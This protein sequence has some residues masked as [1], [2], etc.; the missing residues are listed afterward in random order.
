VAAVDKFFFFYQQVGGEDAWQA[1]LAGTRAEVIAKQQPRYVTVLDLSPIIDETFTR[2]QVDQVRYRGP[3]YF[4]FDGSDIADVMDK[5]RTFMGKL[6][7][8]DVDPLM[9]RLYATGGRGFHI[10]VPQEIFLPK[11]PKQGTQRLPQIYKEMAYELY[12]DTLDLRVYSA[13]K[14]RMWR[15]VN[16]KRENGRFKVPITPDELME[17]TADDYVALCSAPREIAAPTPP[18][19]SQKLA[20][21]Y[22]KAESKIDAAAKKRK[23]AKKDVELLAKFKG[24]FPPSLERVMAG[25]AVSEGMGFHHIALQVAITSN[26][27][28][29]AEEQMLAACEG[30]IQNHVSDSPRYGTPAKRRSELSRLFTYTQDNP[31]YEYSRDAVRRLVPV[32]TPTPDLD[33]L[34]PAA[35]GEIMEETA[36]G[37]GEGLFEG[38]FFAENGIYKRTMDGT[39]KLSMISYRDV[40][41]LVSAESGKSLG[42]EVE[43]LVGGNSRG[44]VILE[45]S[46]LLTKQQ[47]HKFCVEHRGTFV[48]ADSHAAAIT[49]I[50]QETAMKNDKTVY[51]VHREGLDLIRRPNS[52]EL[53]FVWVAGD[54]VV[55]KSPLN[56]KHRGAPQPSPVFCSDLFDA[57]DLEATE[58]SAEVIN[59][60]L[61]LNSTYEIAVLVAW[62]VS[63]FQRQI[64]H[65][66]FEQFPLLQVYGQAGAGKSQTVRRFL[67]LHYY[68]QEPKEIM[69]SNTTPYVIS[70]AAHASASIPL[71]LDEFKGSELKLGLYHFCLN[72]MRAAY[73]QGTGGKGGSAEGVN[74]SWKDLRF[75]SASSP[76]VF[77]CE[78]IEAQAAMLERCAIIGLT[79][80][81][82][83]GRSK[84][85]DLLL[86]KRVVISS[87]G[88]AILRATMSLEEPALLEAFR[89][90]VVRNRDEAA[91][92]A[93][94]R[95]NARP[96]FNMAVLMTG[97]D[98][99]SDVLEH[100]F[101]ARF[102]ER[103]AA[104]QQALRS[105][106]NY[107]AITVM[108]EAAKA[109]NVLAHISKTEDPLSDFGLRPNVDYMHLK[110]GT[111]DIQVRNCYYK[112]SGW[113]RKRGQ[114]PLYQSEE[115][116]AAGLRNFSAIVDKACLDNHDLKP[117]GM[118]KV[119][120]YSVTLLQQEGVEDFSPSLPENA[121]A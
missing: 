72:L 110:A 102:S 22:A 89:E 45:H 19:L 41:E 33:G 50:L 32:G 14:G 39:K 24:A 51:L 2:E 29:K 31:C 68:R 35:S 42:F 70:T 74:A 26:A 12:V 66:L 83:E 112:Y 81:G 28:G 55:T 18:S 92:L 15:T 63:A 23:S 49:A 75:F 40:S 61:N 11:L 73:L 94:R 44:R 4:D 58:D 36:V 54:Q 86:Q 106:E 9:L 115:A 10:E 38:V 62:F 99:L 114:T 95:G 101:P 97:L 57:P 93:C 34:T 20:V 5:A 16:V 107:A 43:M 30:L 121:S 13:R 104:M 108:P 25:E 113:L 21:L 53:D 79:K 64:Y 103:I 80:M 60:L 105:V 85:N 116:W 84:Y 111:I 56:Y 87:L 117:T 65:Q 118:E 17:M 37:N 8:Q 67:A 48:G 6:L 27:L 78:N 69:V 119:Y 46:S 120:R 109:L 47:Y 76:I 77:M 82:R 1:A 88:K 91:A 7:E 59:A 90:R 98:F 100:Y 96:V 71:V 52:T 3:L